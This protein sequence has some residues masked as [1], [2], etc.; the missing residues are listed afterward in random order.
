M[1]ICIQAWWWF[2]FFPSFWPHAS[3][4]KWWSSVIWAVPAA[5]HQRSRCTKMKPLRSSCCSSGTS[6][7]SSR[8]F[9]SISVDTNSSGNFPFDI[10]CQRYPC[11]CG[12]EVNNHQRCPNSL[13]WALH[14]YYIVLV[15]SDEMLRT[16]TYSSSCACCSNC[17]KTLERKK[18]I[19]Y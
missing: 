13:L 14:V 1:N 12:S 15:S 18:P 16:I 10:F 5:K 17:N 8:T 6:C 7:S 2:Q 9:F 4:V 3:E 19:R 11:D